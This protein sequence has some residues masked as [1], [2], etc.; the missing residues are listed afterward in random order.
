[1]DPSGAAVGITDSIHGEDLDVNAKDEDRTI[2]DVVVESPPRSP[3][4]PSLVLFML[5][6]VFFS[7]NSMLLMIIDYRVPTL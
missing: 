3:S 6:L 7:T 5:G 4:P 2:S 1:M